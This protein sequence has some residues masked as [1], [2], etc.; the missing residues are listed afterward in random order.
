MKTI[1]K[2]SYY[3]FL[4]M[5]TV[6]CLTFESIQTHRKYGHTEKNGN[7]QYNMVQSKEK[8]TFIYNNTIQG[9]P[10]MFS[11]CS[12]LYDLD[13]ESKEGVRLYVN[14]QL[15][16]PTRWRLQTI[17]DTNS[18]SNEF[19]FDVLDS[20]GFSLLGYD[21]YS[22]LEVYRVNENNDSLLIYHNGRG[23][24]SHSNGIVKHSGFATLRCSSTSQGR[25]FLIYSLT[26]QTKSVTIIGD[27]LADSLDSQTPNIWIDSLYVNS[28][29]DSL[30]ITTK[31][32]H[33]PFI[34]EKFTV[35][36]YR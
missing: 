6:S 4:F 13:H 32:H 34:P 10:F 22:D 19:I 24:K 18:N 5:S 2:L 21:L 26:P 11:G 1:T 12:S 25:D 33:W 27:V 16:S 3:V 15:F 30:C 20:T 29:K 14:R 23:L 35:Y 17:E 9:I 36:R 31:G 7:V 28:T 8:L